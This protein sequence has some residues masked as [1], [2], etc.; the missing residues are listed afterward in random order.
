[1]VRRSLQKAHS[2]RYQPVTNSLRR[3]FWESLGRVVH[4]FYVTLGAYFILKKTVHKNQVFGKFLTLL[5][6]IRDILTEI[7]VLSLQHLEGANLR[8]EKLKRFLAA[9]CGASSPRW[10]YNPASR[11]LLRCTF[12]ALPMP[13]GFLNCCVKWRKARIKIPEKYEKKS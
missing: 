9:F 5:A 10:C 3:Y 8:K 1:M 12:E 13:P 2:G 11:Q 4:L 7:P 6:T